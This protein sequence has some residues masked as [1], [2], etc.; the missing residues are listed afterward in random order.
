MALDSPFI[1]HTWRIWRSSEGLFR[2]QPL[3]KKGNSLNQLWF[4]KQAQHLFDLSKAASKSINKHTG[5]HLVVLSWSQEQFENEKRIGFPVSRFCFN[6]HSK[7]IGMGQEVLP[8]LQAAP[9]KLNNLRIKLCNLNLMNYSVWSILQGK[10]SIKCI[11]K[12]LRK[13]YSRIYL[14]M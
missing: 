14:C 8:V 3:S 6:I 10:V 13:K 1:P 12:T 4:V 5:K 7:N 11:L 2:H 9:A